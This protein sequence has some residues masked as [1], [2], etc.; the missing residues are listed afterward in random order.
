MGAE[1][2]NTGQPAS[3]STKAKDRLFFIKELKSD[4]CRCGRTKKPGRSFCYFCYR[5]LPRSLQQDLYNRIGSG[6]E[7][8]Y[9]AACR[10]LPD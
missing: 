10:Y 5:K 4:E 6:Y 1:S 8:A 3:T 2:K 9:E 7:Q